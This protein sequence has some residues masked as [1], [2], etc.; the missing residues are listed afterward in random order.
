MNWL[1]LMKE[2]LDFLFVF[3]MIICNKYY[4]WILCYCIFY[5]MKGLGGR[6]CF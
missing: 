6:L 1:E 5:V 3:N 2:V 4:Y